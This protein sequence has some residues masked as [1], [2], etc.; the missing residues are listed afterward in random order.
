M[1][2]VT[3]RK[4]YTAASQNTETASRGLRTSSVIDNSFHE[5]ING[6]EQHK[7]RFSSSLRA[8]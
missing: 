3:V 7:Q 8:T 5:L 2:G 6:M 1:Y 4:M